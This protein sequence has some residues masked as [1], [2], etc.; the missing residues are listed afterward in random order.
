[1][2]DIILDSL[3]K[4]FAHGITKPF[5]RA[6]EEYRLFKSGDSICV[7]VSGGKDSLLLAAL[8]R[9]YELYGKTPISVKYLTMDAG[10]SGQTLDIIRSN[11]ERLDID[12]T[13]FKTDVF[14]LVEKEKNP[15][16]LCSKMRRGLLYKKAKELGCG[17]IALGHHFDDAI[18]SILMGM[19]YGGQAQTM[20]PRVK[21]QNFEGMELIRPLYFVR[22]KDIIEWADRCRIERA[23]CD[24]ALKDREN[25]SERAAIKRLIAELCEENS[26]V[27]MNIFRS[28]HNVRL[29]RIISYKDSDGIHSFLDR[30]EDDDKK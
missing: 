14:R 28:V 9:R 19:L 24:C 11:A 2:K 4:D 27:A 1:M 8:F 17:K 12:L 18:E 3:S 25:G 26:Q 13:I 30:F 23:G 21:A 15:C 29:D 5:Y 20:L 10:F 7:C 16:F 22:E 6:I